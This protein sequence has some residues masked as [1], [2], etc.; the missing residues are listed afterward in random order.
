M[1]TDNFLHINIGSTLLPYFMDFPLSVA[2]LLFATNSL[3]KTV[4]V[5]RVVKSFRIHN[6]TSYLENTQNVVNQKCVTF[7]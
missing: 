7:Q 6:F 4:I 2:F 3:L 1:Y 5:N